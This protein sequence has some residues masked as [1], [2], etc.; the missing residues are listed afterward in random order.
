MRRDP[1]PLTMSKG[2]QAAGLEASCRSLRDDYILG[3]DMTN[4]DSTV[5]QYGQ[6]SQRHVS[7]GPKQTT[8]WYLYCPTYTEGTAKIQGAG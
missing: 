7:V 6:S 2:A 5:L 8:G 4:R 3:V 1:E